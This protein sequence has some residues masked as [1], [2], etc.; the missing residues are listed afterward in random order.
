MGWDLDLIGPQPWIAAALLFAG[1]AAGF[2]NT[3]ASSGSAVTLPLLVMIGLSE[4]AANATNRMPVLVG[5][6]M[7]LWTFH[8]AGKVDWRAAWKLAIPTTIGAVI[9]QIAADSIGDRNAGY[10]ITAAVLIALLLLFT[11]LKE[12]LQRTSDLPPRITWAGL[13]ALFFVG[14][15]LGFIVLDGATYLLLVL[16]LMLRY[17]LAR[18]NALKMVLL[19][20]PTIVP[21]L[22]FLADGD[23]HWLG[24]GILSAGA[25]AGGYV[26]ARF[27]TRPEAKTWAFRVLVAVMVLELGQLGVR[28]LLPFFSR[29]QPG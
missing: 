10:A 28:Y 2:L 16:I 4:T 13:I 25:V 7:A 1:F 23:V 14:I 21:T 8:R 15:W 22:L 29:L 27:S 5:S 3:L 12:A 26:G 20:V 19:A 6:L 17:D 9:G 18:A 11:K 24:G